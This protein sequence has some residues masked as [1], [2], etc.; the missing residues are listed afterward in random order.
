MLIGHHVRARGKG[1]RHAVQDD[2]AGGGN[3]AVAC[4][5][6]QSGQGRRCGEIGRDAQ[7]ERGA[8]RG[9]GSR[10]AVKHGARDRLP[11]VDRR[12]EGEGG[13][14]V[15]HCRSADGDGGAVVGGI[16]I[17]GRGA[18]RGRHG[19]CAGWR[20]A[21]ADADRTH[22]RSRRE[23]RRHAAQ[24]DRTGGGYVGEGRT[25]GQA[26]HARRCREI[27]RDVQGEG[28]GAR[29]ARS[30]V[31]VEHG[32][33]DRLAGVDR[34]RKGELGRHVG[35][36]RS[37]DG[38]AG[39]V[40]GRIWIGGGRADR[41]GHGRCAGCRLGVAHT[42][43]AHI[44]A[45]A[46]RRRH[47]AQGDGAGG[48]NVGIARARR[49]A[50]H[51]RRCREIGRN[52]QAEGGAARGARPIVAVEHGTRDR[53][54]GVHACRKTERRREVRHRR[55]ADG[56]GGA[57]VG[58]VR[59][60][61]GRVDGGADRRCCGPRLGVAHADRTHARARRERR[62]HAVQGDRTGGGYVGEGRTGG[63]AGHARRRREIGRD[64][65]GEGGG[66]RGARSIVAVEHGARDRLPGIHACRKTE[67]R[68]EIRHRRSADGGGGAVVGRV[69]VGGGRVD[70]GADRR[71]CGPR[72]GVAD[73]DRT[74]A[75]ARGERCGH[76]VQGDR[77]GG[78]YVGE[79]RTG[80]QAGHA[81]RC[82]EIGR[83]AQA[84]GGG[85]RG[86][87]SIV[88]VGHGARDR[89]T[90]VHAC[91][92][93]ERR[94]DVG[95]GRD[96]G[97]RG[98]CGR[99]V[100]VDDARRWGDRSR[101]DDVGGAGGSAH[102]QGDAAAARQCG[103][104][105][106]RALK[107]GDRQLGGGGA[108]RTAGGAAAGNAGGAEIGDRGILH[109][110]AR[111]AERTR[112]CDHE[113]VGNRRAR[114]DVRWSRLCD[115]EIGPV[116]AVGEYAA[117]RVAVLQTGKG[118]SARRQADG[119]S[120]RGA[121]GGLVGAGQGY[122]VVGD[123]ADA[124]R[125]L[126]LAHD[127]GIPGR[128]GREVSRRERTAARTGGGTG[129][130]RR[131]AQ[132]LDRVGELVGGVGARVAE[133]RGHRHR[134]VAHREHDALQSGA[135]H[136]RGD[137][138]WVAERG[139]GE[140]AF[141][142][143][144]GARFGH[145]DAAHACH[146]GVIG[147]VGDLRDLRPGGAVG[148]ELQRFAAVGRFAVGGDDGVGVDGAAARGRRDGDVVENRRHRRAVLR[149]IKNGQSGNPVESFVADGRTAPGGHRVGVE[150]RIAFVGRD[151]QRQVQ[152]RTV[153]HQ[154]GERLAGTLRQ[155]IRVAGEI[156]P[157]IILIVVGGGALRGR[158]CADV[159]LR[160][161]R[162]AE[163]Q[164]QQTDGARADAATPF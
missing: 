87:R 70:G 67:R 11:R 106:A 77:T 105:D 156:Q 19:R 84:E 36:H 51:A 159:G 46:E 26:G 100:A 69:R 81:R 30:I 60:G 82:R 134:G 57:V 89:L 162:E 56:G 62:R 10:V 14:E 124:A 75:R 76:A 161:H 53:L 3:V 164:R 21:I 13:R 23:R 65:Q 155:R 135:D 153:G 140:A 31:A 9:A 33:R 73:A 132:R 96:G 130:E 94:R 28:G 104:G 109:Q 78:G 66:A 157:A 24:G 125:R 59:V 27:G 163:E 138:G 15:G 154:E 122:G 2:E 45:G 101:I 113:V 116:G 148:G 119:Q 92:K 58:R 40:V 115:R 64:V 8:A 129:G 68:R 127:E 71:C 16:R 17:D 61:G 160:R 43:R 111:G 47:A 142:A 22:A 146:G 42:D 25:G 20:L 41:R 91:R 131:P 54:P 18:D 95:R 32:A 158:G 103:D 150:R 1:R 35:D 121:A 152:R 123:R 88:G 7:T 145:R 34:G 4:A 63:Q 44:G 149:F 86:A 79:G 50:G 118:V 98:R 126:H 120:G 6:G 93:T 133:L 107:V 29:G 80:G 37:A 48:G 151:L 143:V 112:V 141:V 108:G 55:S 136:R 137:H 83:D 90:G 39:V 5:R 49:Q 99:G 114:I 74:H 139:E 110:R 52:A 128:D 147:A 117:D 97:G 38:G 72:L 144:G 12:R 102:D 85:A